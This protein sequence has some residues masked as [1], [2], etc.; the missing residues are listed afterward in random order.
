MSISITPVY[1]PVKAL[2]E[3]QSTLIWQGV[4]TDHIDYI[5]YGVTLALY[6]HFSMLHA[7]KRGMAWI[8]G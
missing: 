8:Q 2:F 6:P 1:L 4:S 5:I 7:K 3:V